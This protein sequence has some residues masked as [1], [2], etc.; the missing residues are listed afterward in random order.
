M[1]AFAQNSSSM[2]AYRKKYDKLYEQLRGQEAAAVKRFVAAVET[3]LA[4]KDAAKI[5]GRVVTELSM[6]EKGM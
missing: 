2:P 4:G 6:S 1:T 5:V 3:E